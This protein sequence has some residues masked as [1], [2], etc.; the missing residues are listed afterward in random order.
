MAD[1]RDADRGSDR[2]LV[3]GLEERDQKRLTVNQ[4]ALR[5]ARDPLVT[6]RFWADPPNT[7]NEIEASYPR[8]AFCASLGYLLAEVSRAD[9]RSSVTSGVSGGM[10]GGVSG[11]VRGSGGADRSATLNSARS[12]VDEEITRIADEAGMPVCY[13]RE[14]ATATAEAAVP[15]SE[16]M[17][18][19]FGASSTW[20]EPPELCR[21]VV[22]AGHCAAI[23]ARTHWLYR[24][25]VP[26]ECLLVLDAYGENACVVESGLR[27]QRIVEAQQ[28]NEKRRLEEQAPTY[29]MPSVVPESP[30][31]WDGP[32]DGQRCA[33]CRWPARDRRPKARRRSR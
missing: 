29:R 11:S 15:W 2:P 14:L 20:L 28:R 32:R 24:Q 12:A 33:D 9:L 13:L 27:R 10:S 3:R 31:S 22:P 6:E 16:E 1:R 26:R 30:N 18:R 23:R 21:D 25:L 8:H 7:V 17:S 4:E 5:F 19:G